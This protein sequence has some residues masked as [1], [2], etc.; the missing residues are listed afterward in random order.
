MS[1]NSDLNVEDD[2]IPAELTESERHRLLAADRRRV[3]LDVI[4]SRSSAIDLETLAIEVA[5]QENET[6]SVSQK[7]VRRVKTLLHHTHLPKMSEWGVL[8]Y[9][10][11]TRQVVTN[12]SCAG[13]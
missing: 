10:P 11:D 2:E 3:V 9:D 6:E 13:L 7:T 1:Y 4:E 5:M 12:T 8:E